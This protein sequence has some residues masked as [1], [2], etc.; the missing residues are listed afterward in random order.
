MLP[1]FLYAAVNEAPVFENIVNNTGKKIINK[2]QSGT[3]VKPLEESGDFYRIAT[4]GPNGWMRKADLG[5]T[6]GIKI[7][8][9]DVGQGD[10]ILIEAGPLR[11][12]IDAGPAAHMHNYLTKWQYTYLLNAGKP[13]HID[14]LFISHFD[15]D[16]YKGCISLLNDDRF[17]FGTIY[18]PGIL[19]FAERNNPYN[20]TLGNTFKENGVT[21]LTKVFDDLL[22]MN[23]PASFNR[24]VTNFVEAILKAKAQGR[25]LATKRLQAK[26]VPLSTTIEGKRLSIEALAPFTETVNNERCFVYWNDESK[27]TNGHS[28]VLK[29]TFGNRN[30]LFCGDLNSRSEEYIMSKYGQEN[31][32]RTDVAKSCHHGS[33]D[34]TEAFMQQVQ[35]FATV[36]S[37]GDNE[38]YAHP[39]AD[40]IGS[41]GKYARGLRPLVYSTELAR[42]VS[43]SK[44]VFGLINVRS[45]G[46]D[47]YVN[48][49]KE[50]G[51]AA[52][53]WDS[54]KL[55]D[56]TE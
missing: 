1:P 37:S 36:I 28:I 13:V 4:A 41:A 16:H 47:I 20:T 33:S 5:E 55:P 56:V 30:F 54:Y 11:I 10:G 31:P 29:L 26:E 18:H 42:S 3:Y 35:P 34:F 52:D 14:Y 48:Q 39:R 8:Y 22:T 45:N 12:L 49:M 19:K 46:Q 6:M 50:A 23:E 32:F 15:T 38:T 53:L 44:I 7:F 40:A 25:L 21:W 27:T 9:L 43:K 24:D 2:I 17:T 51:N